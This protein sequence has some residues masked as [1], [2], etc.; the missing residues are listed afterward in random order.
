MENILLL[1]KI[2][3]KF[4]YG[5]HIITLET[6]YIAKHTNVSIVASMDHTTLM[7]TVVISLLKDQVNFLPL[8]VHYQER[9]YA[10]GIIPGGFLRREG[11]PSEHETLISRLIDRP[12][13]PLFYPPYYYEIQI[14]V[15]LLSFNQQIYPEILSIIAVSTALSIALYKYK[16]AFYGPIGASRIGLINNLYILNPTAYELKQSNLDLIIAGTMHN[17]LMMECQANNI[18]EYYILKAFKYGYHC[19][20]TVIENIDKMK[21]KVLNHRN[22][23]VILYPPTLYPTGNCFTLIHKIIKSSIIKSYK[24]HNKILRCLIIN[25]IKEELL[26]FLRYKLNNNL[27][28]SKIVYYL[29]VL[30]INILI[31]YILSYKMRLDGRKHN[32]IRKLYLKI[33][34]L[35][36][37]HGS[38]LFT[39]G[40]TQALVTVTL[41]TPRDAQNIDDLL[42]V[43]SVNFIL[44][45]NFP[46]YA[47]NEIG[48]MIAPKRREIGHG[49]LAKK[50][51]IAVMPKNFPYTIRIVSEIT[52]SNGS[53]S[54]ATVCGASLALMAAGVPIQNAVGGIA[55]GLIKDKEKDQYIILSDILG[56]EDH[57]GDIDFKIIGTKHGVTALQMDVK[58]IDILN[59]NL[60]KL[61]LSQAK[62]GINKII[63]SMNETICCHKR[64]ISSF[65]PQ[66]H[67]INIHPEKIKDVI[68]KGGFVIRQ[69]TEDTG[70]II[71]IKDKGLINII[72][73][74]NKQ[75]NHAITK[76]KDIINDYDDDIYVGKI[77]TGKVVKIVEFGAFINI[78][79]REGLLHISNI[80]QKRVHK[81]SDYLQIGQQVL[82]KVLEI[83]YAGKIILSM[84]D[85]SF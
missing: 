1:N 72:G 29:T 3:H 10:A 57:I 74:N 84:K 4:S 59:F 30:E 46:P 52:S 39:R 22:N 67:T 41:G 51:L 13:R 66:I 37:L 55:M 56:E 50:G 73:K 62:K 34:L 79:R 76:I 14:I 49:K 40:D 2:I 54:M 80:M 83:N 53:S 15:T 28:Y 31:E 78:K 11:R 71:E 69:I 23:D 16:S 26:L 63:N 61:I 43:R 18:H 58:N 8:S 75:I 36:R 32:E 65:A 60:I 21:T 19:L 70:T 48:K 38:A 82:V 9:S 68:G 25:K 44:H 7:A 42:G 27:Y 77:Y 6:G 12:I 45:Y 17:I 5:D 81:V 33:N 85:V 35:P 24:L 47:V 64:Y 20:K